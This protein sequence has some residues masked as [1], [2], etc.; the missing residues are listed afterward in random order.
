MAQFSNTDNAANSVFWAA[1]QLNKTA[2]AA[3]RTALFG[4]STVN[5][6]VTGKAVGQ[7][8]VDNTE[9]GV[10]SGGLIAGLVIYAGTGYTAN[11]AATITVT[12]G[13]SGG[14]A[15][16]TANSTGKISSV[17]VTTGS[18][19][20]TAPILE[21]AAPANTT[22]NSNSA[23]TAGPNGGANSVITISSAGAFVINDR[24]KYEC[25]STNTALVGLTSG[26]YYYIQFANSTV[27]ALANS[28]SG[29]R[30][31]L[32]KGLTQT[33]HAL[34]GVRA[35]GAVVVGGG[36]NTGVAH[37]GWVLRTVGTGGRAGR[38]QTEVLVAM[39]S[40]GSD[41]SDDTIYPDS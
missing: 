16:A 38:V 10:D 17:N 13:G 7:F 41:G 9:V 11:A 23:V 4:N 18:G 35:T 34:Q 20:K 14:A 15:N 22:F 24:V 6:F 12:N 40:L 5:A 2:N 39:G 29:D 8:G 19:Y 26:S 27:V 37:S 31:T 30:I 28:A 33:G 25:S 36:K 32:T 3:N 1:A 21:I